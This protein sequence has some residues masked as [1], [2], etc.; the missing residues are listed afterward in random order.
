MNQLFRISTKLPVFIVGGALLVGT[1]IGTASYLTASASMNDIAE[2]H[3]E[4]SAQSS[5][6]QFETYLQAIERDLHAV[7][8]NPV[9]VQ[10]I[11]SFKRAWAL[12][13]DPTTMLQEAYI[14][15]NPN[16]VGEK[17]LLDQAN[18]GQ[19]YDSIHGTYHSWFRELQQTSG[20][21]DVFLFDTDGNLIYS[22][23]KELD[24]ATN[25]GAPGSD[26][27]AD[28]DLGNVFR[29]AIEAPTDDPIVFE[30]FAPYG[31][32]ADAPASFMAHA[33]RDGADRMVGVLAYQMPVGTINEA[34]S[35]ATG[36]GALGEVALIGRDGFLRNDSANTE[37][38]DIL[39]TQLT[40]AFIADAFTTG[41]ASGNSDFYRGQDMRSHAVSFSF[42]GVDYAVVAMKATAEK[43][44]PVYAIRNQMLLIG[45]LLILV[46]AV[47]GFVLSRSI[48][49]PINALVG[50]MGELAKGKT[51]VA[52][53][54]AQRSDEIGDM[55]KAVVI[56]R[57]AMVERERLEGESMEAASK[58]QSRQHEIDQLIGEFRKDVETVVSAV[59]GD[60][61]RMGQAATTLT[62][63]ASDTDSQ[64]SSA[65]AASE[66]ASANVQTVAAAAE[67]LSAS[68]T[69]IGRQV[70]KTTQIVGDAANHAQATNQQVEKLAD[71]ANAIGNVISLIQDIAE[72][73]NLLALNATIEAARA[74]EA[75][76]GFAVVAS[77]V[78]GLANQTAKATGDIAAQISE[79]QS[80]TQDAV[81]AIN[82]ITTTMSEVDQYMATIAASVDQQGSA[83]DEISHNVAQAAHGTESV[84][85]N[86]TGVTEATTQTSEA[87]D[88][89]NGAAKSVTDN[90]KRLDDTIST[91]LRAV[92]AA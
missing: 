85:G 36:L 44:A 37:E 43:M 19:M 90:T 69:E 63:V 14:T 84:V 20:Y 47:V 22:V 54:G 53:D 26:V 13:D 75:G 27:W 73:T 25:F 31:P 81:A 16:P 41:S 15:N 89:V 35:T 38:S 86:I 29:A 70:E 10:A 59:N 17:H 83:T 30:D 23:F 9:T 18:S 52:L 66:E 68:I 48:T 50:E 87:A 39:S 88:D 64:A 45:G 12:M 33:V 42:H 8:T 32:S 74:G 80:S 57:D 79:I 92:S 28:T 65:A 56:F 5:R 67:E 72:Q 71:T 51:N 49:K 76:K 58:R 77:E 60:A 91:F 78:K 46:V 7:A 34:F 62:Q 4:A 11:N 82:Q 61:E 3:L 1:G 2:M 21:Y 40:E 6:D 24:F 55:S